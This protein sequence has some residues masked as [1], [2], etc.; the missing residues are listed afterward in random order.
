MAKTIE[1]NFDGYYEEEELPLNKHKC[2][3]IYVVYAGE[4]AG[5][6]PELY[7]LLYIGE[8]E[9]I[10]KRPSKDHEKY[11]DW[12]NQLMEDEILYFSFAEVDSNYREQAEAALIYHYEPI[13]NEQGIESFNYEKTKIITSGSNV[14]LEETFTVSPEDD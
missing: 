2:S 7:R 10:A 5:G 11:E 6:G 1:L 12:K 9:N 4:E 13:C 3:G 8:S 14:C